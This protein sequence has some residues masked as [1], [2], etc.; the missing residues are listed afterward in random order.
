MI[1]KDADIEIVLVINVSK[2]IEEIQ[3]KEDLIEQNGNTAQS[4]VMSP[5]KG[6][7]K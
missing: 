4:R 6:N 7:P 3:Y 1:K 2:I 5:L